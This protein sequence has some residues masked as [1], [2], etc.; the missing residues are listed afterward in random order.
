MPIPNLGGGMDTETR[1]ALARR[2]I[3]RSASMIEAAIKSD[4]NKMAEY[5]RRKIPDPRAT[6]DPRLV[7]ALDAYLGA[8]YSLQ[9]IEEVVAK[10]GA[11]WVSVCTSDDDEMP[12][13]DYYYVNLQTGEVRKNLELQ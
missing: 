12:S 9:E 3:R 6:P 11:K 10:D 8:P 13:Y 4:E 1:V 7:K 2:L 5:E